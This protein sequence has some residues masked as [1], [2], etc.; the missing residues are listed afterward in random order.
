VSA[1]LVLFGGYSLSKNTSRP[2][3]NSQFTVL[4]REQQYLAIHHPQL[5]ASVQQ[6][7]DALVAARCENV[8]MKLAFDDPEYVIWAMLRN[9]GFTGVLQHVYVANESARLPSRY[10][11]PPVI[12]TSF[13]TIPDAMTNLYPFSV[14]S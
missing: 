4:S 10:P 2:F 12:I 9:R 7:A 8:G 11:H 13:Q 5:T 14:R 3:L 6:L 1:G